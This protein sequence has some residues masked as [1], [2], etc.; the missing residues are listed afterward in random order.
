MLIRETIYMYF[1]LCL[2]EFKTR[3]NSFARVDGR[4][5]HGAKITM[6]TTCFKTQINRCMKHIQ[7][8]DTMADFSN[9]CTA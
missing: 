4:K 6:Y 9:E 5:K 1:Y 3:Q 2:D 8:I 7:N